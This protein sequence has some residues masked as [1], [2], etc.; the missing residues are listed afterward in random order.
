MVLIVN[1][2][3]YDKALSTFMLA[4]SALDMGMDVHIYFSFMGV[5]IIKKGYK[6]RL[7]GIFRFVTGA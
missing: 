1:S 6:P 7:P 2:C 3:S 5:N 4:N